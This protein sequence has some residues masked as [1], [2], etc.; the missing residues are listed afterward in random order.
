LN[1][2]SDRQTARIARRVDQGPLSVTDAPPERPLARRYA[3]LVCGVSSILLLVSGASEM[4]FGYR[5]ARDHIE[6]VQAV[7]AQG[8]AREISTYLGSIEGGIRNVA[9]MPWGKPGFGPPERREEFYRLMLLVP[10]IID[11]RVVDGSARERLY[12]SKRDGDRFDS[13]Q[14]IDEPAL[15]QVSAASPVRH[16][17][18]YFRE[19]H[20]P[21]LRIAVFDGTQAIVATVDLRLLGEV[22]SHMHVGLG[23]RAYVVDA[24]GLLIAHPRPTDMLRRIDLSRSKAVVR[25]RAMASSATTETRTLETLDLQGGPVLV[26]VTR[27]PTVDWLVF[28]EQPRGEALVPAL[29]TLERTLL[30]MAIGMAL[31]IAAGLLFARRMAAPII[32]LRRATRR[33]AQGDLD[34]PLEVHSH[35]EVEALAGDFNEM[36]IRLRASYAGLEAK[37]ADRTAKLSEA[38][39]TLQA[40][41]SEI[42]T[43][44]ERL[45]AQLGELALRKDDAERA[46]AA[47]TRFLA[48]ASHDLRQPM[49]SI[50]L[51]VGVLGERLG[52][53]TVA[54]LV[55]KIQSSVAVMERL[56]GNLLDISKLDAGVVRPRI[57]EV[58]LGFLLRR[59]EQ[60]WGP[61]AAERGLQLRVRAGSMIVLSDPTLLERI[62]GNLVSNA[63]RY[64]CSGGVLVACRPMG[65]ACELQV[66]DTGPGIEECHRQSIF[67]EFFRIDAPGSGQEK[68][69]G[70]GL[71]IVQRGAGILGHPLRLAS[72]VGKGSLFAVT[73]PRVTYRN[74]ISYAATT[75]SAGSAAVEGSFI[76]IVDDDED[77]RL[78]LIDVLLGWRCHVLAAASCDEIVELSRDHLRAPDLIIT[79]FQLG[80]GHTGFEAIEHLRRLYDERIPA[81]VVTANTDGLLRARA[82]AAAASLLHKPIGL[83]LLLEAMLAARAPRATTRDD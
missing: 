41:A 64:T 28:V 26:T 80:A 83:S 46:N 42:A 45:V 53:S 33:I 36:V 52:G 75:D 4:Y 9:Q 23:G 57:E 22:V 17:R 82:E 19:G 78:A 40:R 50:S 47:K 56:F 66:W 32:A 13:L 44:N 61:Q 60:T 1:T 6:A 43:L 59:I 25:A 48:T 38:R 11:L 35:D 71:S 34:S 10:A 70:L 30:L 14:P 54:G 72:R 16:G 18:T 7:Q 21:A 8:A 12:V 20:L 67:E 31:A 3:V 73:L 76:A 77:N 39:D 69:L 5:E 68:G 62:V 49:H 51:L 27:V 24:D 37:V 81:L 29:A 79:D 58:D 2:P 63:I 74:A 55:D 15:A 65:V